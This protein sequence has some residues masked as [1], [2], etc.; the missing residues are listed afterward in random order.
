VNANMWRISEDFWDDWE[1]LNHSFDLLNAWTPHRKENRWPDADMIPFGKL[2]INNRPKGLERMSKFTEDEH[3]T[4]MS[5]WCIGRSP[6]MWGGDPLQ[7][8]MQTIRTFLQNKEIIAINQYS[9][10][11]RQVV[12]TKTH[13]IWIATDTK[14]ADKYV[15]IFNTS[16]KSEKIDFQLELEYMRKKYKVRDLWEHADLGVIEKVLSAQVPSH[17]AKV[18]RLTEV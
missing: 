10:D 8:P 17:G 13:R 6:L 18:F 12:S 7:T 3:Y 5:L 15:A 1:D 9:K 14:S 4:L 2:A 11:N 16:E